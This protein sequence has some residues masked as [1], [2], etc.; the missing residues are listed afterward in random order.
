MLG[1]GLLARRTAAVAATGPRGQSAAALIR[2]TFGTGVV[3]VSLRW[4]PCDRPSTP[5]PDLED[6][7]ALSDSPTVRSQTAG[8][9]QSTLANKINLPVI[10]IVMQ[11][12]RL[13]RR[14]P[15]IISSSYVHEEN[16]W[17]SMQPVCLCRLTLMS[18]YWIPNTRYQTLDTR[19]VIP[20][21][22]SS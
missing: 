15:F 21:T 7:D 4:Y 8:V 9:F 5:V 3:L 19:Y 20:D 13:C 14:T 11:P 17:L 2:L 10:I 18:R 22:R 1:A 12:V 16:L 6:R